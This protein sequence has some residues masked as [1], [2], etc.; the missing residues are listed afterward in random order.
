[1]GYLESFCHPMPQFK[2][3]TDTDL[4]LASPEALF[5]RSVEFDAA[6]DEEG[7]TPQYIVRTADRGPHGARLTLGRS[8]RS[9]YQEQVVILP[10]YWK[11][12]WAPCARAPARG[13]RS[14][15]YPTYLCS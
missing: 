7:A 10:T 8:Q 3:P 12:C 2:N 5:D 14:C 11:S 1:M 6:F 9:A 4:H 15:G 13:S